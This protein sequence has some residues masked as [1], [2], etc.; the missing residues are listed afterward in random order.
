MATTIDPQLFSKIMT[1]PKKVRLDVLEFA[2]STP[3]GPVQLDKI[4]NDLMSTPVDPGKD[5]AVK[6]A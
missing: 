1:L 3:V 6:V 4:I 2:G 5:A